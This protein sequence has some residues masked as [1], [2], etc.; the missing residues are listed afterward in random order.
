MCESTIE[1]GIKEISRDFV[2]SH[3]VADDGVTGKTITVRTTCAKAHYGL[4]ITRDVLFFPIALR[5]ANALMALFLRA[6]ACERITVGTYFKLEATGAE[7]KHMFL[8]FAGK[9]AG[10]DKFCLFT[11]AEYAEDEHHVPRLRLRSSG[12]RLV[13]HTV[14]MLARRFWNSPPLA[15]TMESLDLFQLETTQIGDPQHP[16]GLAR[17]AEKRITAKHEVWNTRATVVKPHAAKRTGGGEAALSSKDSFDQMMQDGFNGEA[18]QKAH[19]KGKQRIEHC[20]AKGK[21]M[22]KECI[23]EDDSSD[24]EHEIKRDEAGDDTGK[25]VAGLKKKKGRLQKAVAKVLRRRKVATGKKTLSCL[26]G[27]ASS[28]G[29]IVPSQPPGSSKDKAAPVFEDDDIPLSALVVASKKRRRPPVSDVP[30]P[31]RDPPG[32]RWKR[33]TPW[34]RDGFQIALVMKYNAEY[35]WGTMCKK[36]KNET[37]HDGVVCKKTISLSRTGGDHDACK[38]ALKA[39]LY[40][41]TFLKPGPNVRNAHKRMDP[42]KVVGAYTDDDLD[43]AMGEKNVNMCIA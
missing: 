20:S 11:E 7:K 2:K 30:V 22:L 14:Y 4:C 32:Q 25:V 34:G 36:H 12:S 31:E 5:A 41:G 17:W 28:S 29:A 10:V 19:A 9:R 35:G 24:S 6:G 1:V 8:A 39:W 33:G 23:E 38:R 40:C 37:D 42:L 18:Y 13:H 15:D 16:V 21:H 3:Y 43:E 26:S 27:A